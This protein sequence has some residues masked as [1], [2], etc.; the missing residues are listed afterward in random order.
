MATRMV[1]APPRRPAGGRTTLRSG[2]PEDADE[3]GRICFEAFRALAAAHNFP[4]DFPSPEVAA[5]LL[6]GLL[7][8][9]GFYSVVAEEDGHIVGTNF[10]DERS[11]IAGVGPVTVDPEAQDSGLGTL[12]MLDVL[13][14]ARAKEFAGTRLLQAAYHTRSLGLY[15]KL[16]FDVREAVVTLQG[17]SIEEQV[18]GF[19]VRS[20]GEQDLE[21]ANRVCR[22]VHGHERSGEVVDA[23]RQGSASVVVHDGTIVGY[24]TG[25]AYFGHSVATS[26]HALEAL[27]AA[28]PEFGGPG[29]LLPASNGD[30][31]G[32]ALAQGLRIVQVMTLMTRGLYN[33]P[34][35]AYLPSILY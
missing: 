29:F 13:E 19:S 1:S 4:P 12:L 15:I 11:T 22:A 8:D 10:L 14:R 26:N 30:V 18:P 2:R 7:A 24:T 9:P 34:R 17:A 33:E 32:W 6:S 23:I 28:A 21:D 5:A 25:I 3:A 20:A 35:G 27:I 31:F 16:G